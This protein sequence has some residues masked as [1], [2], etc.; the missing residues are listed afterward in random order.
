MRKE[1][2]QRFAAECRYAVIKMTETPDPTKKLFYFSVIF[3]EAQRLLNLQ[4]D[5]DLALIH[6][7]S[8][9]VYNITT[10]QL[11]FLGTV[12]PIQGDVVFTNLVKITSDFTDYLENGNF[13]DGSEELSLILGRFAELAYVVQ[14]NGSYLY[15]KGI[16]KL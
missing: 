11:P 12:L 3:G 8:Q 15:E 4:W 6:L 2:Q 10:Q 5:R 13:K 1:F 16:L 9:Q 7:V 14:G